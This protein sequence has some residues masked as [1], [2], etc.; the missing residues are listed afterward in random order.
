MDIELGKIVNINNEKIVVQMEAGSQCQHC[1]GKPA[2]TAMGGV[3]RQ[4]EIPVENNLQ[5]GDQ[6]TINYQ[7]Q[8]RIVSAILVFLLPIIFLIAGYCI[9]F[10]FFETEGK[11][12]LTGIGGLMLAFIVLWALNK[13]LTRDKH[14]LPTILKYEE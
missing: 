1:G 12:I 4:I 8:S 13:I 5:V 11:A 7:F 2:C 10:Y 14:F 3:V 6:V 9:G